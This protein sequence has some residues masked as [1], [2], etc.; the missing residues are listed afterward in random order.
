MRGRRYVQAVLAWAGPRGW[1]FA[2]VAG[3]GHVLLRHATGARATIAMSPSDH[4]TAANERARLRR[5]ER[6]P[7]RCPT[8]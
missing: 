7:P 3:S 5:L 8:A 4:R 2:G 1:R 6:T